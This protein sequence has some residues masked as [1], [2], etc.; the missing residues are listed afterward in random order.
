[1]MIMSSNTLHSDPY[2]SPHGAW[3]RERLLHSRCKI[4]LLL[5]T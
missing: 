4:L 3:C 1:M 5:T 2:I